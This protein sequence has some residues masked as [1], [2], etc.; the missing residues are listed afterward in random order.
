MRCL[1]WVARSGNRYINCSGNYT[2]DIAEAFV[3]TCEFRWAHNSWSVTW[4]QLW[5]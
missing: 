1:G 3:Y 4:I 2:L 5:R